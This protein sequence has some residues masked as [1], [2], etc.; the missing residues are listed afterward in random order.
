[1]EAQGE[2][3]TK[4]NIG[5]P[6]KVFVLPFSSGIVIRPPLKRTPLLGL[7]KKWLKPEALHNKLHWITGASTWS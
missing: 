3:K 2:I 4:I 1:M 5:Q 6:L 7:I